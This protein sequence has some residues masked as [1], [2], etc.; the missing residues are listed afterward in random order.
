VSTLRSWSV[1]QPCRQSPSQP[2]CQWPLLLRPLSLAV[3]PR[4][5]YAPG[6]EGAGRRPRSLS[7]SLLA[8]SQRL[9][10]E[11]LT[12]ARGCV[13]LDLC[14]LLIANEGVMSLPRTS[15][16]T[17]STLWLCSATS[18]RTASALFLARAPIRLRSLLDA[19]RSSTGMCAS[20]C[21]LAIQ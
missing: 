14:S 17:N 12:V 8:L 2:C 9:A 6:L 20:A 15:N 4:P 7:R 11:L 3:L 5:L 1:V 10:G 13:S 18:Q 19:A 16:T 21:Y